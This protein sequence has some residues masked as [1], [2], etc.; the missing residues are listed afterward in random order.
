MGFRAFPLQHG[1]RAP[2][3]KITHVRLLGV[4]ADTDQGQ[5]VLDHIN[6]HAD[7]DGVASLRQIAAGFPARKQPMM[8]AGM[9]VDLRHMA[10]LRD[11]GISEQNKGLLELGRLV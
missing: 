7:A 11:A 6:Q 9:R 5:E 2:W 10:N 4:P 8:L 3:A 1:D